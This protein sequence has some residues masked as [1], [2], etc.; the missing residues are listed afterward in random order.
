MSRKEIIMAKQTEKLDL[1]TETKIKEVARKIFTQKGYAATRTRDIAQEAGVNL[2]LLNYY[3]RSKEKLFEMVI[4]EE[5]QRFFGV[6]YGI[7]VNEGMDLDQKLETLI[8]LYAQMLNE[9]PELPLFIL[10]EIQQNPKRF[11]DVIPTK[12]IFENSTL[13]KQ[14]QEKNPNV[15]PIQFLYSFVGMLIFPYLSRP[16]LGDLLKEDFQ[17]VMLERKPLILK[18]VKMMLES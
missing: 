12:K 2:A 14:F 13:I 15:A 7:A 10:N 8:D 11:Q 18:W 17:K 6:V 3:F 4:T 9:N 16:I 5:L 1:S